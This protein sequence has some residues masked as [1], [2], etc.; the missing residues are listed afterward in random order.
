[1]HLERQLY[2]ESRTGATLSWKIVVEDTDNKIQRIF[3][4]QHGKQQHTEEIVEG[5]NIGKSNE[6]TPHEQ[7]VKEAQSIIVKKLKEGFRDKLTKQIF[8]FNPLPEGFTPSKPISSPPDG[9]SMAEES[10]K[11]FYAER[12]Y[13]GVNLLLVVDLKSKRHLYTRGIEEITHL[14]ADIPEIKKL[15]E[16][17]TSAGSIISF[18]FIYFN[19][20]G[21][22]TP[23]DLRAFTEVR[24]TKEKTE[25]RY[26]HLI[27]IGGHLEIK[28][29]DMLF[30]DKKD[31]TETDFSDRR[32]IIKKL[33]YDKDVTYEPW[34][35]N[36][37]TQKHLDTALEQEWEGFVLRH[38]TGPTS[39]VEYTMNGKAYRKGSWKLKFLWTEDY[40]IYEFMTSNA[41]KIKGLPARFHLGKLDAFGEKIDC[42]WCGPGKLGINGL[43][44]MAKKLGWSSVEKLPYK[45]AFPVDSPLTVEIKYRAKQPDSNALEHPVILETREDKP[46][47]EC[48]I[49]DEPVLFV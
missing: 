24:S 32:A 7:A 33:Y 29:F 3:G 48:L 21:I 4:H 12:K 8:T 25:A 36:A 30:F 47:R 41:G 6:T 37:L 13:N 35:T 26:Q 18:E 46:W 44:G 23:K 28:I 38:L 40:F 11:E 43:E 2:R 17:K 15:C 1:M 10:L 49:S 42:G 34:S 9:V 45:T 16:I 20:D 19:P 27:N 22:E 31:I 39:Y 5:K 14:I